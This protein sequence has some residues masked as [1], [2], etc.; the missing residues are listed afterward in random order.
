MEK[1]LRVI[2]A[3]LLLVHKHL[4]L[5]VE[6]LAAFVGDISVDYLQ[7]RIVE[8]KT[9]RQVGLRDIVRNESLH[10]LFDLEHKQSLCQLELHQEHLD[11][12]DVRHH[13]H[14]ANEVKFVDHLGQH[15]AAQLECGAA[16]DGAWWI[17]LDTINVDVS[18]HFHAARPVKYKQLAEPVSNIV[19]DNVLARLRHRFLVELV[20]VGRWESFLGRE[21]DFK[22]HVL[23]LRLR[24]GD[25][26]E[27][28]P[29]PRQYG[30]FVHFLAHAEYVGALGAHHL[31]EL[32][33]RFL[34]INERPVDG[35]GKSDFAARI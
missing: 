29:P 23:D 32:L 7:D 12:K 11:E 10:T 33:D 20:K 16:F 19:L 15:L 17:H 9:P 24:N 26:C 4:C 2:I 27:K 18:K 14:A 34:R 3:V 22:R 28:F 30:T 8:A 6:E 35:L 31:V 21:I 25:G 13:A 5:E 1:H